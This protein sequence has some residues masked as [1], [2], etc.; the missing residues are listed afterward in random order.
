[1]RAGNIDTDQLG[2]RLLDYAK[3]A[4]PFSARGILGELF[5]YIFDASKRMST[6]AISKWLLGAHK[7]KLSA[8]AIA[9]ALK[10]PEK[11]LEYFA[12]RAEEIAQ[13]V[14]DYSGV[15]IFDLLNPINEASSQRVRQE[16]DKQ[17]LLDAKNAIRNIRYQM[18]VASLDDCWHCFSRQLRMECIPY[19]KCVQEAVGTT[20]QRNVRKTKKPKKEAA[21]GK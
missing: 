15:P 9:N 17:N 5:P 19:L 1:M 12:S 16:A 2:M 3:N 8:T 10:K 4:A 13:T 7:V 18:S 14:S 21:N 20:K 6:H 11:H